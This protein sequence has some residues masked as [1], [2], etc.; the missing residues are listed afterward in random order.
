MGYV[1][2]ICTNFK[3]L[4]QFSLA[5]T[6]SVCFRVLEKAYSDSFLGIIWY[7]N[8][9]QF[10]L[11]SSLSQYLSSR[12][13]WSPPRV[14]YTFSLLSWTSAVLRQLKNRAVWPQVGWDTWMGREKLW[15]INSSRLVVWEECWLSQL[16]SPKIKLCCCAWHSLISGSGTVSSK[17]SMRTGYLMCYCFLNTLFLKQN[18]LSKD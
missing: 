2:L 18:T 14:K 9:H 5:D 13:A 7:Q 17:R 11:T 10:L 16:S 4:E 6:K 15:R 1:H 8:Y 3:L 12:F